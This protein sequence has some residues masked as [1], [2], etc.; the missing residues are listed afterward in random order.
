MAEAKQQRQHR[1]ASRRN[2]QS[3]V[4]GID[5]TT[6]KKASKHFSK[7]QATHIRTWN[8]AAMRFKE[9]ANTKLCPLCQVPATP[10]HIVWMCKWHHRQ[11]HTPLPVP[12]TERLQDPL[13]EPLVGFHVSPTT[14]RL[15]W[16]AMAA[17]NPWSPCLQPWQGLSAVD[18]TPTSGDTRA[19]A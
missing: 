7:A 15:A 5:G 2:C 8:Q 9:G 16:K 3:L 14:P 17:G 4:S 18:A 11:K 12:W 6:A 13:E 10:K 19:Q 1:F